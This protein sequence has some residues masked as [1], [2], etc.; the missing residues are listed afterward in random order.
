MG[1]LL[2]PTAVLPVYYE[3]QP[4]PK[5]PYLWLSGIH[6]AMNQKWLQ[7]ANITHIVNLSHVNLHSYPSRIHVMPIPVDDNHEANLAP[8]FEAAN[9]WID[10]A[11]QNGGTV[12]VHCVSGKS[13]SPSI[14]IGYLMWK[15]GWNLQQAT[16]YLQSHRSIVS[17]NS[18]FRK[19]LE[20]YETTLKSNKSPMETTAPKISKLYA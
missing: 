3:K 7:R 2:A 13:R 18:V 9:R 17:P 14:V 20:T 10:A 15:E 6:D 16:T 19:Q 12:L 8:F 4:A 5:Q 1:G 11:I